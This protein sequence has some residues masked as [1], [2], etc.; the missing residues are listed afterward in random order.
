MGFAAGFTSI[1]ALAF[2]TNFSSTSD[3]MASVLTLYR[4]SKSQPT[5]QHYEANLPSST[6]PEN[7]APYCPADVLDTKPRNQE[8]IAPG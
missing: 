7:P 1:F 5:P 8:R 3:A 6:V 4:V 2:A